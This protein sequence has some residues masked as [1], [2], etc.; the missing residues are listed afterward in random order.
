MENIEVFYETEIPFEC[1]QGWYNIFA[2][3]TNFLGYCTTLN[4]SHSFD[5]FF[6]FTFIELQFPYRR[7]H[8]EIVNVAV[9]VTVMLL[10]LLLSL[11]LLMLL[12]LPLILFLRI[13]NSISSTSL[14]YSRVSRLF[15][16]SVLLMRKRN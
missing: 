3:R 7:D 14:N 1:N 16:V 13:L 11:L 12:L 5:Q 4:C 8:R 9:T 6:L 15:W 2:L 10:L